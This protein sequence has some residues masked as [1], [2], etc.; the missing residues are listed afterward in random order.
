MDSPIPAKGPIRPE[1]LGRVIKKKT[2]S[3]DLEKQKKDL[4]TLF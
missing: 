1:R 3:S 2:P 4:F